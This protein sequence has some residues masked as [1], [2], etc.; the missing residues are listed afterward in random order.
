MA[1]VEV[2]AID[3]A[4]SMLAGAKRRFGK[5]RNI[6]VRHADA[7]ALPYPDASFVTANIAN[8]AHCFPDL[9]GALREVFRVLE[10]GGTLAANVLLYPRGIPPFRQIAEHIDAW[11]MRKGLLHTPY[12][13]DEVRKH[14]VAAGFSIVSEIISGNCCDVMARKPAHT[15]NHRTVSEEPRGES[16]HERSTENE[17]A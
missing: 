10:P 7:K 8:A 17:D 14:V 5:W 11:G 4:E 9:S 1:D 3:C 2:V 12:R 13:Q 16:E 6:E 15:P